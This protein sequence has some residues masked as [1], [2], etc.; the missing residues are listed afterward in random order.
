MDKSL[1][2]YGTDWA[3]HWENALDDFFPASNY[4]RNSI[5]FYLLP[6]TPIHHLLSLP[7]SPRISDGGANH[8]LLALLGLDLCSQ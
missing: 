6:D 8:G 3:E 1:L 5:T 7:E 4:G 2:S